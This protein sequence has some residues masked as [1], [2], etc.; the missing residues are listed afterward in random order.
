MS[1]SWNNDRA[2]ASDQLA[3][4]KRPANDDF[5]ASE[6][7]K[8]S[9]HHPSSPASR[10]GSDGDRAFIHPDRV[11]GHFTDPTSPAVASPRELSQRGSVD[12]QQIDFAPLSRSAT[13]LPSPASETYPRPDDC[14]YSLSVMNASYSPWLRTKLY[15]LKQ[16]TSVAG[17]RLMVVL[18]EP[19][20]VSIDCF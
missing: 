20:T 16:L 13:G 3:G 6:H 15:R 17:G 10:R 19:M 14:M 12:R 11:R 1:S 18:H 5:S 8:R 9:H 4:R 2:A 7:I